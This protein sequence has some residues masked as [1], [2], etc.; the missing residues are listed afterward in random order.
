ML[1]GFLFLFFPALLSS[2][3]VSFGGRLSPCKKND[4]LPVICN[5]SLG[6]TTVF[7]S[8]K[9]GCDKRAWELLGY[10]LCSRPC[11]VA[12]A[13]WRGRCPPL[14]WKGA[15]PSPD[16]IKWVLCRRADFVTRKSNR[17][18]SSPFTTG[19]AVFVYRKPKFQIHL[20]SEV[21]ELTNGTGKNGKYLET[22]PTRFR[23]ESHSTPPRF[24]LFRARGSG[25]KLA[26][27][28]GA[29]WCG[30]GP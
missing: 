14:W 21:P 5:S 26:Q 4:L 15:Q 8:I 6:S 1:S 17:P 9:G 22:F 30:K 2:P 29:C 11:L 20:E 13:M 24:L 23:S 16:H 19:D 27:I 10:S 18:Q 28:C 3:L 25:E 7:K 12:D